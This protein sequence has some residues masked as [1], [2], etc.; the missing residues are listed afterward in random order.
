MCLYMQYL[1]G[2]EEGTGSLGTGLSGN[3]MWV[4]GITTLDPSSRRAA[5]ALNH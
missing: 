3:T 2:P 5:N 4:L 1:P